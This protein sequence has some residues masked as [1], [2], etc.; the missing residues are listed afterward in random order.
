MDKL[1]EFQ[2]Q[3]CHK[4]FTK[5]HG[6]NRHIETIH[7]NIKYFCE[8]CNKSFSRI[9]LR[10]KHHRG[11]SCIG[12]TNTPAASN[13][14]NK[15]KL[16]DSSIKSML[17][18]SMPTFGMA[19]SETSTSSTSKH[20]KEGKINA[21]HKPPTTSTGHSKHKPSATVIP[22]WP[23][24]ANSWDHRQLFAPSLNQE[25]NAANKHAS[26]LAKRKL[27]KGANKSPDD[28]AKKAKHS[29][30]IPQRITVTCR[31][32]EVRG[33]QSCPPQPSLTPR[34]GRTDTAPKT[35]PDLAPTDPRR[36]PPS[37]STSTEKLAQEL[38]IKILELD[39][40]NSHDSFSLALDALMTSQL[41]NDLAL[42]SSS[43]S[44]S[45]KEPEQ[46][47]PTTVK[48]MDQPMG[49]ETTPSPTLIPQMSGPTP[50]HPRLAYVGR[51]SPA[52]TFGALRIV[53]TDL[54]QF[55]RLCDH[56]D[57]PLDILDKIHHQLEDTM[58]P[59]LPYYPK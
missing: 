45:L 50:S 56:V 5:M 8:F 29:W 22:A 57:M 9:Y 43:S 17:S 6:L 51:T 18:N 36:R 55:L 58:A 44:E 39:A 16:Q 20:H 33:G 40:D 12:A 25:Q 32:R 3:I 41:N 23:P 14:N 28:G 34:E 15:E 48:A 59:Y 54:R 24:M 31:A 49:R 47:T 11:G 21:G 7:D 38:N 26:T 37:T 4:T 13:K 27:T 52:T 2:C 19:L 53:A 35:S 30:N 1:F 46:P 42:S 10:D